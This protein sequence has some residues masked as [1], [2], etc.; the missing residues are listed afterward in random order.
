MK[1]KKL[2]KALGVVLA[3]VALVV[4][5]VLGTMAWLTD[6]KT[7]TNTVTV[8]NVTIT[9]TETTGT[10]YELI[11]GV[12]ADKDPK[13]TVAANSAKAYVRVLVTV[14]E[15]WGT[16]FPTAVNVDS[17]KWQ[18]MN[19]TPS[20]VDGKLTYEYRYKTIVASSDEA[21]ELPFFTTITA[22]TTWGNTHLNASDVEIVA[23]AIQAD[24]MTDAADA[25][26]K[27]GA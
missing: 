5:S 24:G 10:D 1:T 11:P 25:W 23:N 12:A 7:V 14:D 8:G 2:L 20:A 13:V 19:E 22:P 17:S 18:L 3:A 27:F 4:V 21:Q 26:T 15:A 16:A 6:T 9:L